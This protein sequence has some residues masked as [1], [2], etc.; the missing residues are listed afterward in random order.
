MT[1]PANLKY[2]EALKPV[3]LPNSVSTRLFLPITSGPYTASGNNILR[4]PLASNQFLDMKNAVL[5]VAI[6]NTSTGKMYLDG[7]ASSFVQRLSW[8][9]GDGALLSQVD[10]YGKLYAALSNLQQSQNTQ[11]GVK[12]VLEGFSQHWG[13]WNI[14][15]TPTLVS[16]AYTAIAIGLNGDAMGTLTLDGANAKKI[17]VADFVFEATTNA[18]ELKINGVVFNLAASGAAVAA[19]AIN[20]HLFSTTGANPQVLKID[21]FSTSTGVT[22]VL[23]YTPKVANALVQTE[24]FAAGETR[25]YCIPLVCPLTKLEVLYPAMA[26]AGAVYCEIQLAQDAAVFFSADSSVK[27]AYSVDNCALIIPSMQYPDSVV[28]SFRDMVAKMGSVSMSSIDF[29]NYVY[30]FTGKPSRMEI[31]IAIKG[32]S[33]KSIWFTVQND[34]LGGDYTIPKT[35]AREHGAISSIQFRVGS[36]YYPSQPVVVSAS[37]YAEVMTETLKSICALYDVRIGSILNNK[38]I[39][40]TQAAGG[41]Q[42]YG[43]DFEGSNALSFMEA[44]LDNQSNNLPIYLILTVDTTAGS[45]AVDSGSVNI[46]AMFDDSLSLLSNGNIL[47]TR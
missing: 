30:S 21:N 19:T 18:N 4:I 5:R 8:F 40:L 26:V 31:P 32:R 38:N 14:T 24:L 45:G 10:S 7:N 29:Q 22:T 20:G 37:N 44:G 17:R 15:V 47:A 28:A 27:P 2:S 36:N 3:C 46:W 11:V 12:N 23:N 13:E 34:A 25:T 35:S 16:G 41:L 39:A 6:K 43:M 33:I 42:V 9:G 1:T